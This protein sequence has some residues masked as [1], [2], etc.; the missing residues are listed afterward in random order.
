MQFLSFCQVQYHSS[1]LLNSIFYLLVALI[2]MKIFALIIRFENRSII[3][4]INCL[5]GQGQTNPLAIDFEVWSNLEI[6]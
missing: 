4:P 3:R 5:Q 6:S 1:F 2:S